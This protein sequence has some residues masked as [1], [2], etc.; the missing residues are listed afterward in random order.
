MDGRR[1]RSSRPKRR[2]ALPDEFAL[3]AR[4]FKP[5]ARGFA[6]AYGLEDDLA[7]LTPG[8]DL[9]RAGEELVVKTDALVAGVHFRLSDPADLVARKLL[10]VN[11][12]DLAAKGARPLVYTLAL[13]VPPTL[14]LD[15]LERFARGLARD[16]E[17]FAIALAG[18]D[19]DRTPGPLAFSLTALGAIPAGARSLRAQAEPGD[20]I[21]VSGTIGDG[22]LGLLALEGK[23][24]ALGANHRRHLARRYRLPEPRLAL[25]ARLRGLAHATID[26]S[27]G[28]VADLQHISDASSLGARLEAARV[29][30]SAAG[31]AALAR[32]PKLVERVL[33]GGD[34]YEIL[35]T[36]PVAR[37]AALVALGQELGVPVTRIGT[38]EEARSPRPKVA[39]RDAEGRVIALA[40]TG[41]RHF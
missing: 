3:I 16:Q 1:K 2:K 10:R 40:T 13:F 9:L 28:L 24:G 31:R 19:T 39:L 30:L 26:V 29:P 34:D 12:S 18:G 27:D 5:L 20:G 23:L 4:L 6:G 15:W 14:D 7:Y 17:E 41:Y 8:G 35:L 22:A 36:A 11:L 38:M 21:F 25:G 33:A 32:R 37:E